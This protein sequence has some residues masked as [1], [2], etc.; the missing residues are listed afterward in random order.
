MIDNV[1]KPV[2][3]SITNWKEDYIRRFKMVS[4][5]KF[6]DRMIYEYD[7]ISKKLEFDQ[8]KTDEYK[9]VIRKFFDYVF[10]YDPK[11]CVRSS[12]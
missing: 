10:K 8:N 6:L 3:F 1:N 11:F 12:Y 2:L 4:L 7:E 9:D 5:V